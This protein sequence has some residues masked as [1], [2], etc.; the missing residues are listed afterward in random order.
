MPA[1]L[2]STPEAA[3]VYVTP[4]KRDASRAAPGSGAHDEP[5]GKLTKGAET[6]C[7]R[8]L[9]EQIAAGTT[10]RRDEAFLRAKEFVGESLSER[11]FKRAWSQEAPENWRKPGRPKMTSG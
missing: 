2:I 9:R 10:F 4:P 8:W 3:V 6:R 7:E 5:A 11:A 1:T